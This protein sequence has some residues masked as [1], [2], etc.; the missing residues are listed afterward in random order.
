MN[1]IRRHWCRAKAFI[2]RDVACLYVSSTSVGPAFLQARYY[3]SSKGA[4]LSED[5]ML[6]EVG[7]TE[8]GRDDERKYSRYCSNPIAKCHGIA[9][10]L[11]WCT[12]VDYLNFESSYSK[13]G[14]T[15]PRQ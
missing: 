10:F 11:L 8:T 7:Q 4:F 2:Q 12:F 1:A 15:R 14:A 9:P 3:D 6:W 5:P 13:R